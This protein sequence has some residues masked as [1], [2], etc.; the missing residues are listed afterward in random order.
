MFF[1]LKKALKR[2]ETGAAMNKANS[3]VEKRKRK[4]EKQ[5]KKNPTLP[6]IS[7]DLQLSVR[8]NPLLD[9]K[10]DSNEKLQKIRIQKADQ[11]I[12][13]DVDKISNKL[14]YDS[15]IANEKL[16]NH[17]NQLEFSKSIEQNLPETNSENLESKCV[18][19]EAVGSKPADNAENADVL[20]ENK[21]R[22]KKKNNYEQKSLKLLL[23]TKPVSDCLKGLDD[24]AM[25]LQGVRK[26]VPPTKSNQTLVKEH[27]NK[28]S[29]KTKNN[30]KPELSLSK[31]DL[32]KKI[33][34]RFVDSLGGDE[35]EGDMSDISM[36]S[37]FDS[38]GS[39]EG[40]G[41][42]YNSFSDYNSGSDSES[43][44]DNAINPLKKRLVNE[45]EVPV[46]KNRKGQ[47]Q[48]RMES[49]RIHG[50]NAK[51]IQKNLKSS[52]RK[53]NTQFA[54]YK[55]PLVG[56][57]GQPVSSDQIQSSGNFKQQNSQFKNFKAKD[58]SSRTK[59]PEPSFGPGSTQSKKYGVY[60]TEPQYAKNPAEPFKTG[61]S[62]ESNLHTNR[63]DKS[64]TENLHPSWVAK[65]NER[66]KLAQLSSGQ[67][68]GNKIV[69]DQDGKSSSVSDMKSDGHSS[70][71]RGQENSN[72][73]GNNQSS[74]SGNIL[75]T[76]NMHPSWVAKQNERNRL[77]QLVSGQV[78][79]KK[80]VFD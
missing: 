58:N 33:A 37:N 17:F 59:D 15:F 7:S 65:Q 3:I 77:A 50:V 24:V 76:E 68:K 48:R 23:G 43:G 5:F 40:S 66:M 35:S 29:V 60:E 70:H 41:L 38:V 27:E 75:T 22:F 53:N 79:G 19:S 56:P 80:I 42:D 61:Q 14:F 10:Q 8:Q 49:E 2:S 67:L 26:Q 11:K 71:Y 39:L 31:T 12:S 52:V 57:N 72:K 1:T 13:L 45:P 9:P 18:E 34:S 30:S 47:R 36:D 69:F 25:I 62:H 32:K 73:I 20:N 16:A 78:K 54:R 64:G 55:K 46:K 74:S 28:E 4:A 63:F 6:P 51:H 44:S 21:S